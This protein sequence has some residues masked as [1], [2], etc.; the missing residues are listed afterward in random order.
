M[1][2]NTTGICTIAT[3]GVDERL[4]ASRWTI[5]PDEVYRRGPTLWETDRCESIA[6]RWTDAQPYT[7]PPRFMIDAGITRWGDITDEH[8]GHWLTWTQLKQR[9]QLT[10]TKNKQQAYKKIIDHLEIEANSETARR[11]RESVANRSNNNRPTCWPR[12]LREEKNETQTRERE[13]QTW[14][15]EHI[16]AARTTIERLGGWEYLIKWTDY[17]EPTWEP[18]SHVPASKNSKTEMERAREHL[19]IPSSFR[20]YIEIEA[21]ANNPRTRAHVAAMH[22]ITQH[23]G[24]DEDIWRL[25]QS[26]TRLNQHDRRTPPAE[27]N[28]LEQPTATATQHRP[29]WHTDEHRTYYP[30]ITPP[31]SQPSTSRDNNDDDHNEKHTMSPRWIEHGS[32]TN[33]T[34]NACPTTIADILM[35]TN[36]VPIEILQ[37]QLEQQPNNVPAACYHTSPTTGIHALNKMPWEAEPTDGPFWNGG[38]YDGYEEATDDK[39]NTDPILRLSQ[40]T[41]I[42]ESAHAVARARTGIKV[43]CDKEERQTLQRHGRSATW[44][45]R[46][47]LAV[48]HAR[49]NFTYAAATDGSR[50]HDEGD[51]QPRVACGYYSGIKTLDQLNITAR[52]ASRRTEEGENTREIAERVGAGLWG[53]ALP[54]HWSVADAECYAIYAY[55]RHTLDDIIEREAV[56]EQQRVLIATDNE[57]VLR[58]IEDAWR[59]VPDYIDGRAQLD[60]GRSGQR[61]AMIEA[62]TNIRRQL[63][64]VYFVWVP[65]HSGISMNAYADAVA[66]AHLS[67]DIAT[68]ITANIA[69]SVITR[70]CLHGITTEDGRTEL[71]DTRTYRDA[72]TR[73]H[74]INNKRIGGQQRLHMHRSDH[75]DTW[76]VVAR[77]VTEGQQYIG[78]WDGRIAAHTPNNNDRLNDG[79]DAESDD[80]DDNNSTTRHNKI[81]YNPRTGEPSAEWVGPNARL[82]FTARLRARNTCEHDAQWRRQKESEQQN[83]IKEGPATW[84]GQRGCDAGC[85]TLATTSHVLLGQCKCTMRWGYKERMIHLLDELDRHIPAQQNSPSTPMR[86]YCQTRQILQRARRGLEQTQNSNS[87]DDAHALTCILAGDLPEPRALDK[88]TPNGQRD[89]ASKTI[90]TIMRMQDTVIAMMNARR[91]IIRKARHRGRRDDKK[92][93]NEAR[94]QL[95]KQHELHDKVRA[96][97]YSL[98]ANIN[99]AATAWDQLIRQHII[100][101]L[102]EIRAAEAIRRRRE[103]ARNGAPAAVTRS[104]SGA[105]RTTPAHNQRTDVTPGDKTKAASHASK[106]RVRP[107]SPPRDIHKAPYVSVAMLRERDRWR[108]GQEL[109]GGGGWEIDFNYGRST[110][111]WRCRFYV[112]PS[113]ALE[114]LRKQREDDGEPPLPDGDEGWGLYAAIDF[115]PGHYMLT[116]LGTDVGPDEV[117]GVSDR[118]L[119]ELQQRGRE[120][121]VMSLQVRG[122]KGRRLIDGYDEVCGAQYINASRGIKGLEDNAS[123]GETGTI[124]VKQTKTVR[125]GKVVTTGKTIYRNTEICMAYGPSYWR[126]VRAAH[127]PTPQESKRKRSEASGSHDGN[128]TP[129]KKGGA[130]VASGSNRKRNASASSSTPAPAPQAHAAR[131]MSTHDTDT[132]AKPEREEKTGARARTSGK[133]KARMTDG[134]DRPDRKQRARTARA[135]Q[136]HATD[137]DHRCS[138]PTQN[139]THGQHPQDHDALRAPNSTNPTANQPRAQRAHAR[140]APTAQPPPSAETTSQHQRRP[141]DPGKNSRT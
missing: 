121:H 38:T 44:R 16:I 140:H 104:A 84:S 123:F 126:G 31:N 137:Q 85:G 67:A 47:H 28:I 50:S 130:A 52:E 95:I 24:T 53:A 133:R 41:H 40:R 55:L 93:W 115:P 86:D 62:I 35:E 120:R 66:K 9:H 14:R 72:W 8:T 91:W 112:R 90:H 141:K 124:Q 73:A 48:L 20:E 79:S 21:T 103:Y 17:D 97:I 22:R 65:A 56:P 13:Q 74:A 54:S 1:R 109:P 43:T 23:K 57:A 2:I 88:M 96:W 69:R 92:R 42:L 110:P 60:S 80:A 37:A 127:D 99:K 105:T 76:K 18:Q 39:I 27:C 108:R 116:Y 98:P 61:G 58:Q 10:T 117:P 15:Y 132:P 3:A 33:I 118:I 77:R 135:P 5:A 19:R 70:Q 78:T 134:H 111:D 83:A 122:Q 136:A 75:Q 125:G 64:G 51:E 82:G 11:W 81:K 6:Y 49:Y 63:G 94:W 7:E 106:K 100:P 30:G 34:I 36:D 138:A 102:K 113:R 89:A 25:W 68:D 139:K 87:T 128:V 129:A 29:T 71:R 32:P 12:Q 45:A 131:E 107:P 4:A 46:A 119:Q 101:K 114:K 59:H 26:Y